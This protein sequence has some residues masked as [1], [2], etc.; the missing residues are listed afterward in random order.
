MNL[1]STSPLDYYVSYARD[2]HKA[3]SEAHFDAL[4][5]QSGINADANRAAAKNYRAQLEKVEALN[6]KIKTNKVW[7]GILIALIVVAWIVAIYFMATNENHV[8]TVVMPLS[9]IAVTV[10]ALLIIF[11]KINKILKHFEEVKAKEQEKADGYLAEANA[12]LAPLRALFK[13]EDIFRLI[14]K[15]LPDLKFEERLS[16]ELLSEMSSKFDFR[17]AA[18]ERASVTET[19]SG[20]YTDNPFFFERY[21]AETMGSATYT[22]SIVIH[23]TTRSRDSKGN[24]RTQHHTQTL[25]ATVTKPKPFYEMNTLLHYGNQ[26]AP[27]LSF[28][29]SP[30]HWENLTEKQFEKKIEDGKDDLLKAESESLKQGKNFTAMANT[31]FEVA[32]GAL[33]RSNEQQYRILFTPLAQTDMVKLMRSKEGYGDDFAFFKNGRHNTIRSEHAQGW[34][35]NTSVYSF[36]SYDIDIFRKNFIFFSENFFKSLFFD[37][38]PLLTIP[39]YQM[40]PATSLEGLVDDKTFTHKDYEAVVNRIGREKFAH[41]DTRSD[42]ILKTEYIATFGNTDKINVKA[43]SYAVIPRVDYISKL[44]GDG[45]MH[46]IPVH[47]DEYIPLE[48]I[49]TV[50]VM[51]VDGLT[52]EDFRDSSDVLS[53]LKGSDATGFYHGLVA[54]INHKGSAGIEAFVNSIV[55]KKENN[56]LQK[57]KQNGKS[58]RRDEQG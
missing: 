39:A 29:R 37:L 32:F 33:N 42:V 52:P 55:T 7:R 49:S 10:G 1:A 13:E 19:V 44:G 40:D 15:L 20:K 21:I 23:W 38:A 17:D 27:D 9:A 30:S 12:I 28:S 14:E 53:K 50:D 36:Y 16:S 58:V 18:G 4:L 24:V 26:V 22:G 25:Y 6:K 31:E 46:T 51:R 47:W 57:E 45:R 35:M 5:G 41:P 43:L 3:N 2:A 8:L 11:L 54:C 48:R 34:Q 56:T